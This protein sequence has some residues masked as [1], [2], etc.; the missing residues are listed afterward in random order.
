M[1]V[2]LPQIENLKEEDSMMKLRIY[3]LFSHLIPGFIVY[4]SLL[5][6]IGK[7]L[8][9]LPAIEAAAV[10]FVI[11]FFI[12]SLSGIFEKFIYFTW[13]G[14]PS[15]NI[16]DGKT[17]K[18]VEFYELD[19]VRELLQKECNKD[20]PGNKELFG[21]AMRFGYNQDGVTNRRIFEFHEAFV[22]SR[23]I[24]TSMIISGLILIYYYSY[25]E[26]IYYVL[27]IAVILIFINWHSCKVRAYYYAREVLNYYLS[28]KSSS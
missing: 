11:G 12:D 21:A 19:K 8:G 16:L 7:P 14:R 15:D 22:F 5:K 4:L 28:K 24:L 25:T 26:K 3:D 17:I 18:S 9:Y 27:T 6:L 10:A 2:H 20:K 1:G 13:G 23:N